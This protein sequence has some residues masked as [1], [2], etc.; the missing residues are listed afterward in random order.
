MATKL[1]PVELANGEQIW[2]RV[3][4][5]G[6]SNV[7]ASGLLRLDQEELR[8]TIRS[9]GDTLWDAVTP[10][11]P[12]EVAIEFGIELALK[13]GKLTSLLAEA[14]GAASVKVSLTWKPAPGAAD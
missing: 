10:L 12:D 3:S 9:V 5:D 11:K 14:S 4:V 13:S 2:A 6:P 1:V 8:S 7:S